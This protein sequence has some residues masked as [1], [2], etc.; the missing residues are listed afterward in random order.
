MLRMSHAARLARFP[1]PRH[2]RAADRVRHCKLRKR[3]GLA[4]LRIE[5]QLGPLADQLAADR[6]LGEW[7]TENRAEIERALERMLAIYILGVNALPN[8]TDR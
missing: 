2:K 4:V 3:A 6:F 7:N 8:P 1:D 5:V